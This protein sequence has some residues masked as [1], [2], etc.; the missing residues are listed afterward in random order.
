MFGLD[1]EQLLVVVVLIT[2]CVWFLDMLWRI[3]SR[4][5]ILDMGDSSFVR[6]IRGLVDYAKAFFPVLLIV[7]MLRS[8]WFEPF[9]IPSGSMLPTLQIGDFILVN[10][11]EYGIRLPILDRQIIEMGAP[12]RGDVM[13]F[14]FPHDESVNFIKRVVG[15]AGDEIA[16]QGKK[17]TINGEEVKQETGGTY[18]IPSS[19][20]SKEVTQLNE[21]LTENPHTVL[22]DNN[23][24]PIA[25]KFVVPEGNFFVLGDNRDY[26][27]DSRFWGFVPE[28][29]I[30]G[31]AF[32][33]WF[34]WESS[35]GCTWVSC[36]RW[37]R[38]SSS[39]Q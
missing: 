29:N 10:K 30:I 34:S 39:I 13:V 9:R 12:Q 19:R 27:N 7:L 23:Q 6:F 17:L 1:F 18:V 38:I 25:M 11:Y 24:E 21:W 14:K 26:S 5:L 4:A 36:V 31:R 16:Y 8:F 2:G 32:L 37:D 28:E 15:I 22:V 33:I 3:V 20:Q 35:D